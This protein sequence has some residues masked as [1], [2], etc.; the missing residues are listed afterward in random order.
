MTCPHCGC[1]LLNELGASHSADSSLAAE[2]PEFDR[3][4]WGA[5]DGFLG[6]S[7]LYGGYQAVE[8]RILAA[9]RHAPI[10]P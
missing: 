2:A 8:H 6:V 9:C 5:A 3:T 7:D 10:K 4:R 1:K